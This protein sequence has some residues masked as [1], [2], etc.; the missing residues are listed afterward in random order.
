M[1]P[2]AAPCLA[3]GVDT[4]G[5]KAICPPDTVVLLDDGGVAATG[6]HEQLLATNERYRVVLA[7]L[8]AD[9]VEE[10]VS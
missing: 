8:A 6:T 4:V 2:P 1:P 3:A 5:D 10:T 9:D 7:A